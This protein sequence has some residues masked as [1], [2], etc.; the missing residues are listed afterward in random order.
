MKKLILI[1][2]A[3]FALVGCGGGS[4]GATSLPSGSLDKTFANNG[5][6]MVGGSQ[7]DIILDLKCK[8]DNSILTVGEAQESS[9]NKNGVVAL[10][11]DNGSLENSF[12]ASGQFV[13]NLNKDDVIIKMAQDS[14]GYIYGVGYVK[15][16][17]NQYKRLMV[18]KLK[19]NGQLDTNFAFSGFFISGISGH[20]IKGAAIA[21]YNNKIIVGSVYEH[22]SN[23]T[24]VNI[25]RLNS[26][27][28]TVDASFGNNGEIEIGASGYNEIYDLTVDS[29]GNIYAVGF[30]KNSGGDKNVAIAKID[31]NGNLVTSFGGNGNGVAILDSGNGDDEGYVI[32]LDDSGKILIAGQSDNHMALARFKSNGTLDINFGT[33]GVVVYSDK[34]GIAYDL[35][36]DS[37]SDILITGEVLGDYATQLNMAIWKYDTTGTAVTSFGNNGIAKF[38]TGDHFNIGVAIDIDSNDKIVVGGTSK[39][40]PND[41]QATIWRVNP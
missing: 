24:T 22:S 26:S 31:N 4:G 2:I 8:A 29:S 15:D 27:D 30:T 21:I 11:K 3:I 19:Q 28:G 23:H 17:N 34:M 18:V 1:S 20:N 9:N 14:N 25:I 40:N 35:I 39:E 36:I 6:K 16:S 12:G 13:T 7:E 38:D 41:L 32:K 10:F 33:N 37:N 5:V